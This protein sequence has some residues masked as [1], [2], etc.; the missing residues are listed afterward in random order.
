MPDTIQILNGL[1]PRYE[2]HH[3][4]RYTRSALVSAAEL[5]AKYV[6]DR[7]L[8]D[9]AIDIIDEAGSLVRLKQG[10]KRKTVNPQDIERVIASITRI[11]VEKMTSND[12]EQ[13]KDL[14]KRLKLQVFGQDDAIRI[15]TQAI[16]RSRAGLRVRNSPSARFFS[17]VPPGLERRNLRSN[18]HSSWEFTSS[19]L[20]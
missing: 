3:H 4:L 9:K 12:K 14:E 13:L 8:P 7:Y 15:L 19:V 16:K 18:W 11:P 1:K 17:P 2:K 6:N 20:T 10:S 5:S